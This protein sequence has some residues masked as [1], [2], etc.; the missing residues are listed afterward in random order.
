MSKYIQ[1][2]MLLT[3]LVS[4][5]CSQEPDKQKNSKESIYSESAIYE[6]KLAKS[7][8]KNKK[9]KK[10]RSRKKKRKKERKLQKR[11]EAWLNNETFKPRDAKFVMVPVTVYDA[12]GNQIRGLSKKEF[13]VFENGVEQ[14]VQSYGKTDKPNTIILLLDLSPSMASSRLKQIKNVLNTI[15]KK[16]KGL[17]RIM[18]VGFDI[19]FKIYSPPTNDKEVLSKAVRKIKL[20][21]GTS[22]YDAISHLSLRFVKRIA[23]RKNVI[24]FSDGV[25]TTSSNSDYLKS[26]INARES[27][28]VISSVYFNS[29]DDFVNS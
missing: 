12:K 1:A 8:S 17:D 19:G 28:I 15:I 27:N 10:K 11:D 6:I 29:F 7:S 21:T 4:I 14:K 16:A 5:V 23:G 20:G 24:L 18:I 22:I 2:L 3:F 25:D 9:A 26:I 13:K